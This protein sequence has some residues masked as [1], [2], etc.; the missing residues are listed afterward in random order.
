[1]F[2][3]FKPFMRRESVAEPD[4]VAPRARISVL[5]RL[6]ASNW[7]FLVT[8]VLPTTAAVVYYAFLASNVYISESRFVVRAPDRPSATGLGVILRSAGFSTSGDEIYAAQTFATSRDALRALNRDGAFLKAYTRP[9]ISIADRFNPFGFN[10]SFEDL[11]KYFQGKVGLDNDSTTSITTLT[12]RAYTPQDAYRFNQQLLE[13]SEAMVNRLNDRGREDLVRYAQSEVD[14]A[15]AKSQAAA[16]ALAAYRNRSGIV[17]PE[18]QAAA[19][20]EMVSKLQD[21]LIAAKTELAQLRRYAPENPRIPVVV[22]QIG[23]IQQEINREL[24]E[25]AGNKK[26]LAASAVQFQRLTL[27]SEFAD[28]QLAAALASLEDAR[29]ESHRKQAYVERIVQPNMP[30]DPLEP[31]R[32]RGIFGTLVLSLVAYGILR[33]LLAGVKEH[34]Q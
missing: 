23:T 10:G 19:Q 8:V 9:N 31:L 18:K 27:Q 28:K 7:L 21:N 13:M 30:D 17:D 29:S 16:M 14:T 12:V 15:K 25:V 22:T 26:S 5:E 4:G 33:M 20:M 11:Y 32:L 1:M 24:G 2:H 3:E 34:A 6:K